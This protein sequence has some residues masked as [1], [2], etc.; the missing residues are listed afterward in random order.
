MHKSLLS[1]EKAKTRD[2][3]TCIFAF[4]EN[5]TLQQCWAPQ[6]RTL[7]CNRKLRKIS[8]VGSQIRKFVVRLR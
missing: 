2:A 8:M 6:I 1:R 7:F 3:R 4:F 5:D